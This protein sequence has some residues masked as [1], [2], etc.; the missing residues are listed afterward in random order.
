M[1]LAFALSIFM[2]GAAAARSDSTSQSL[3]IPVSLDIPQYT[4]T[5]IP[6]RSLDLTVDLEFY[7]NGQSEAVYDT[8]DLMIAVNYNALLICPK[9]IDLKLNGLG[10]AAYQPKASL[11]LRI[12]SGDTITSSSYDA[13]HLKLPLPPGDY[14]SING[15]PF[16]RLK[17][18]LNK[19]WTERDRKG[20]Y[21]GQ[22]PLYIVEAP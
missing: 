16:V 9:S 8:M 19:V 1:P 21:T 22:V 12:G 4:R 3:N 20:V 15:Y 2:L 11:E 7:N 6:N 5:S 18:T 10:D 13:D 14:G 17:V